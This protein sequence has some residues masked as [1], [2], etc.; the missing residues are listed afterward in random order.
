MEAHPRLPTS[1]SSSLALALLRSRQYTFPLSSE[2]SHLFARA[3]H[4]S[5]AGLRV[6]Y[7]SSSPLV[8]TSSGII[9]HYFW[10]DFGRTSQKPWPRENVTQAQPPRLGLSA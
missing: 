2:L 8:P 9:I 7:H 6:F 5:T 3:Y 10:R 1:S 4:R